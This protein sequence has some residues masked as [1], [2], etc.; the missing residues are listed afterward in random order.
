MLIAGRKVIHD[1]IA[2]HGEWKA[3]LEN[4]L[5]ITSSADWKNFTDIRKTWRSADYVAP[6]VVFNIA[7]N[8]AR[9]ITTIVYAATIVQIHEVLDHRTY[10]RKKF[11]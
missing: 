1:A 9:L 5:K 7:Q 11:R 10:D 8:R 4:W 3:S 6:H 2:R